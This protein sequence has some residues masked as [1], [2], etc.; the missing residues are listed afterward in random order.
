MRRKLLGSVTPNPASHGRQL[1]QRTASWR[2]TK[3]RTPSSPCQVLSPASTRSPSTASRLSRASSRAAASTKDQP[4]LIMRRS[5]FGSP[6]T[7]RRGLRVSPHCKS[8]S[9]LTHPWTL[10]EPCAWRGHR[11]AVWRHPSMFSADLLFRDDRWLYRSRRWSTCVR[12]STRS[13]RES[14]R[15]KLLRL[16]PQ[17]P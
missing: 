1:F 9:R 17:L 15:H 16:V 4:T 2:N 3:P 7:T 13:L 11:V 8:P 6:P 14:L 5:P 12:W 10:H